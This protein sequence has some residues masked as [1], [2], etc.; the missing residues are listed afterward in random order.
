M[1]TKALLRGKGGKGEKEN[2]SPRPRLFILTAKSNERGKV[3]TPQGGKRILSR[4]R[5]LERRLAEAS[6]FAIRATRKEGKRSR[7]GGALSSSCKK[8]KRKMCTLN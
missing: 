1:A 6:L 7:R 3:S 8:K 5:E 4:I 2:H